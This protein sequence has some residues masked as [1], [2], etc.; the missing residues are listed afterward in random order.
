[1]RLKIQIS[2]GIILAA[3]TCMIH[4]AYSQVNG[5]KAD[6]FTGVDGLTQTHVNVVFQD[7]IG[8]LWIGTQDGLN[9]YDGYSFKAYRNQPVDTNSLSNNFIRAV[10]EDLKG[11]IWIATNEGL[12][13]LDRKTG[14]FKTYTVPGNDSIFRREQRI[15]S[16]TAGQKGLVWFKTENGLNCLDPGTGEIRSFESYNDRFITYSGL[17][18]F[19]VLEDNKGQVWMGSKDGLQVFNPETEQFKLYRHDPADEFSLSSN[20]VRVIFEDSEQNIWVGTNKGLNK[21]LEPS[22]RFIRVIP[23]ADFNIRSQVIN[24]I[25]EDPEGVFWIGTEMGFYRMKKNYTHFPCQTSFLTDNKVVQIS[26]VHSI[27]EDRSHIMWLGTFE[28]LVKFDRKPGKFKLMDKSPESIPGL[29][30]NIISAV[31]QDENGSIWFGTRGFGLNIVDPETGSVE[32]FSRNSPGYSHRISNDYIHSIYQDRDGQIWVG[33]SNGINLYDKLHHQFQK[34]CELNENISCHI[35]NN[36]SVYSIRQ[37]SYGNIWF[38]AASGIHKYNRITGEIRSYYTIFSTG[39]YFEITGGYDMVEDRDYNIWFGTEKGL[40]KYNPEQDNFNVYQKNAREGRQD[41][42]SQTI[43][44]LHLDRR[45]MLWAGTASGLNMYHPEKESFEYLTGNE[46]A[47]NYHIYSILEGGDSTLW[48]STN[49]GLLRYNPGTMDFMSFNLSNG[50]QNYEF[51]RGA[52]YKSPN[53]TFYF[54]GISGLNYFNPDSIRFNEYVPNVAFTFFEI[55]VAGQLG[56][57]DLPLERTEAIRVNQANRVFSIAF[58]AL[59]FTAPQNNR[60]MYN[61]AKQ[62]SEGQWISVG[63]QHS[64]TFSNLSPGKYVLSVKGSNND[65]VWN[66]KEVSLNMQILPPIWKSLKAYILY[67]LLIGTLVYLLI[68]VRTRSLRKSNKILREKELAAKEVVKQRE[69]LIIKNKNITDSIHYAQRIQEALLPSDESFRKLLPDSFI[70]YKPKDIVSGDFYWINDVRDK[71]FIAAVDC[72]GHGVPGAFVSIIGFELF[73]KLTSSEGL[74]NPA[75][76]MNAMNANFTEI[77]SEGDEVYLND[78]MDLCLCVIDKKENYLEYSG[79]FNPLYLVRD[80]TIIEI[81]ANRFSV[82]ADTNLFKLA[83]TFKSHRIYLQ[84]N[85]VLYMFSDGYVDQF[86]GPE[87]K[88]FKFRRFRHLLL[89]IHKLPLDKQQAILDASVEEWRGEYDQVDDIMVIGIRM[90]I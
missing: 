72:T 62:G 27:I 89:T 73:R 70:L 7:S 55:D 20:I 43:Y 18:Q 51:N 59:D 14:F 33:T 13:L 32:Y 74:Q 83:K 58:A 12:N 50:L 69:E 38:T 5:I 25:I 54:G 23:P 37:D 40:L 19:N 2:A 57:N 35:F 39:E 65:N 28:G 44:C 56:A 9:K 21:Y 90:E 86:G 36:N 46:G 6:L 53:G 8:F 79:A 52:A 49:R 88:K 66:E 41:L 4:P 29:S 75:E 85:D 77:F 78:G 68:Q 76:I 11:N 34:F 64:V 17:P 48:M 26:S 84:N 31:F 42:S 3:I 10:D 61:L 60:Y 82:G 87:G 16:V 47:F 30:S 81:K 67:A 71:V 80:D 22:D 15:Y 45:G 1:M 63:N 24:C